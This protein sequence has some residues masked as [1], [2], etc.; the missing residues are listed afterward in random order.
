MSSRSDA[1]GPA[2]RPAPRSGDYFSLDTLETADYVPTSLSSAQTSYT[3]SRAHEL[4][5][6]YLATHGA[7]DRPVPIESI[8]ED[9]LGLRIEEPISASARG[10]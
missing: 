4:R 1:A 6:R 8:A 3:E 7:D 10:C 9:L 5:E 2:V